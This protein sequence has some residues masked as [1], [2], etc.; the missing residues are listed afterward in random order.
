LNETLEIGT[1]RV[2]E[3]LEA[4]M[5]QSKREVTE[6]IDGKVEVTVDSRLQLTSVRLLDKS[7]DDRVRR[8]LEQAIVE[9]VNSARRQAVMSAAEAVSRLHESTDWK[10]A[11]DDLFKRGGVA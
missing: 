11:M 6:T 7:L 5:A 9:A 4:H 10:A 2:R 1:R 8:D 3:L